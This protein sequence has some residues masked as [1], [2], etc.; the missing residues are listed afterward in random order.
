MPKLLVCEKIKQLTKKHMT[1]LWKGL[2][3]NNIRL[4][5]LSANMD[6]KNIC[7]NLHRLKGMW[8][9]ARYYSHNRPAGTGNDK[10]LW[11]AMSKKSTYRC[12]PLVRTN[13]ITWMRT[14]RKNSSQNNP[15]KM[16]K[17]RQNLIRILYP[18]R[19]KKCCSGYWL[20][21]N[22]TLERQSSVLKLRYENGQKWKTADASNR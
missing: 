16:E 13:C 9:A 15:D 10:S 1:Q 14:P 7:E 6:L 22:Y 2:I 19:K 18:F 17:Y 21:T 3:K 8:M 5:I 20:R 12:K 4:H 11:E